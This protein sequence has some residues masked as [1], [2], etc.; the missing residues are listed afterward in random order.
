MMQWVF[1][2]TGMV[3]S[4]SGGALKYFE[5]QNSEGVFQFVFFHGGSYIVMV[6]GILLIII[7]LG[8]D[9]IFEQDEL[10]QPN[11]STSG[12]PRANTGG[13]IGQGFS[14]LADILSS[15]DDDS[16]LGGDDDD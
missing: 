8:Y 12:Q 16:L 6:L 14:R 4:F 2:L 3:F 10:S 7:S 5:I 15:D 1:L 9:L 11:L 13:K